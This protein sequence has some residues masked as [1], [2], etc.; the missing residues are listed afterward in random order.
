[1]PLLKVHKVTNSDDP[2]NPEHSTNN[3]KPKTIMHTEKQPQLC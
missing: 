3:Y 1:M 2:N